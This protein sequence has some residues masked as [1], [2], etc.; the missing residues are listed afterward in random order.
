MNRRA[1][2]AATRHSIE[3]KSVTWQASVSAPVSVRPEY[4]E[5]GTAV[6]NVSTDSSRTKVGAVSDK[7]E[8]DQDAIDSTLPPVT[9]DFE[10]DKDLFYAAKKAPPGSPESYWS[11]T[12]YRG[13]SKDGEPQRVKVHYCRSKHTMERVCQ[14]YF[15]NEKVLGFDLEWVADTMKWQGIRRNVSLI[16]LASPSHIGLFH[17]AIFADKL[18]N[19]DDFV[20]P[21]FKKIMEDMAITKVGVAIKGDTTRMR[22]N[23]GIESKGLMELSHLY[24]LVTCSQSGQYKNINKKLV[25]LATQVEQFL[26]LPLYKGSDVR[27]SNWTKPLNMGQVICQCPLLFRPANFPPIPE[28]NLTRLRFCLGRI[29][30]SAPLCDVGIP[31][32]TA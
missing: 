11:Y 16:Q 15:M 26:R 10:I 14:Q 24:K 18:G 27:S 13:T 12:Q 30:W 1:A 8:A 2:V 29:C 32:E 17:S 23:M 3:H 5:V 28:G 22:N 6:N 19:K 9:M 25:P 21:S 31:Q 7:T 4:P 20:A